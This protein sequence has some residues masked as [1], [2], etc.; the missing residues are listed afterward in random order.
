MVL[1]TTTI[2]AF[3]K[4]AYVPVDDWFGGQSVMENPTQRRTEALARAGDKA[5]D[6]FVRA[7]REV[8]RDQIDAGIDVPTDGEVR[9]AN[10]IHYHCRHLEGIDFDDLSEHLMRGAYKAWLPSIKAPITATEP[11]LPQDWRIAQAATDRPVKITLPGP[12]TIA[13]STVDRFYGDRTT[14]CGAL[15]RALNVEIKALADAGC[16]YIQIDEPVFARNVTA[17]LDHGVADLQACF[18]GV[19]PTVN[20]VVHVCLGYPDRLDSTD[21]P[22]APA[23]AYLELAEALDAAL[24][25]EISIEDAHSPSDFAVLLPLFRSSRIVLGVIA[26][27]RSEIES[28][29]AIKQRIATALQYVDVERLII[30][31]DCGL[32]FLGRDLAMEKLRNMTAAARACG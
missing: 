15:A 22:K 31:P 4:P 5:E 28:V 25:D 23:N 17:A 12:M 6:L 13:D 16:S 18:S 21:Y 29:A 2:G 32:G 1:H 3:P 9:R 11:F 20:R 26:I 24:I 10:Y 19:A 8:V 27:A 7:T 14:L 30:A